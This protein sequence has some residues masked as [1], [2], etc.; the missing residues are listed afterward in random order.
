E[1]HPN[2]LAPWLGSAALAK[3]GSDLK[4]ALVRLE[5]EGVSLGGLD[6]DLGVASYVVNPSRQSHRVEDLAL[7]YLGRSLVTGLEDTEHGVGEAAA[8]RARSV[9]RIDGGLRGRLRGATRE[10]SLSMTK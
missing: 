9:V 2:D 3:V 8:G 7:E 5:R 6:F 4:R 10:R 1:F